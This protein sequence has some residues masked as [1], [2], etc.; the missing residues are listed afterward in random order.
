MIVDLNLISH[1]TWKAYMYIR[2]VTQSRVKYHMIYRYR[3]KCIGTHRIDQTHR[4]AALIITH[5]TKSQH[6]H[7]RLLSLLTGASNRDNMVSILPPGAWFNT[8]MSYHY[9]KSHCGDKTVV[10]SSYL[11]NGISYT[12]KMTSLY[13]IA[14]LCVRKWK[15]NSFFFH[16]DH[17]INLYTYQYKIP[18]PCLQGLIVESRNGFF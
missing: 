12:G 1:D 13:W 14:A 8:K 11:H 16:I 9:R 3:S 17:M 18:K 6:K 10:R 7:P 15:H 4:Y 5:Q 2:L